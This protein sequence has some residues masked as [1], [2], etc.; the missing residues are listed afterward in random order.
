[1]KHLWRAALAVPLAAALAGCGGPREKPISVGSKAFTESVILGE[2]ARQLAE[3][4]GFPAMHRAQLAGSRIAWEALLA[5]KIDAYAEYTGTLSKEILARENPA[6][7]EEL[8]AALAERGLAMTEPLGFS[9]NYVVGMYKP[10]AKRLGVERISDL[11]DHPDLAMGFSNE[12]MDREDGW[13]A[14]RRAYGLPQRRVRGLDHDVAY[15]ALAAGEIQVTDFYSTDA[16]LSQFDSICLEDD[17]GCFPDYSAVFLYRKEMV[18]S[19][20]EW[21]ARLKWLENALSAE[22]MTRLNAQSDL[23]R[24]PESLVAADY[25]R[26]AFG[27]VAPVR[28]QAWYSQLA[29]NTRDHLFLVAVSLTAGIVLAVPLGILAAKRPKV[30]QVLLGAVGLVQ[31]IPSI[32]LLVLIV[33]LPLVGGIGDRPAIF[34]LFVYSLLPIVRNTHAGLKDIPRSIV[35]SAEAVGLS[36]WSRLRRIELPLAARSILAGVKT[37][38]VINVGTATLGGFIGAGGFG[39]PIFQGLRR[40]DWSGILFQGALPAAALSLAVLGFFELV[41]RFSV[42]KGLRLKREAESV[43]SPAP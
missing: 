31:T 27:V 7:I 6:S 21:I 16:K 13:P 34:A 28:R 8:R 10:V 38:A 9:N 43:P 23:D 19:A 30:G 41:E 26:D 11:R 36:A 18:A 32:V 5:G 4:A 14:L 17:Q 24:R 25:L 20:P 29:R 1:M 39:Q 42:P 3:D 15:R 37:A 40:D 12:F 22:T 33:P 35:E 2:M